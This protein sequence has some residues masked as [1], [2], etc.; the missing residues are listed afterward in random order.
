MGSLCRV[1]YCNGLKRCILEV[2]AGSS[3]LKVLEDSQQPEH[4]EELRNVLSGL[5]EIEVEAEQTKV[6]L[7]ILEL[8]LQ[9]ELKLNQFFAN[10]SDLLNLLQE[11]KDRAAASI[12]KTA[13]T[14]Y[15][16]QLAARLAITT[17]SVRDVLADIGSI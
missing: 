9:K 1:V 15:S 12:H 6:F 13:T 2:T 10:E 4:A 3:T 5:K 7:P 11:I 17:P 14:Q 8:S 16:T